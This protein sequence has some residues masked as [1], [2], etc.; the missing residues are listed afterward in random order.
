M[1]SDY[2]SFALDGLAIAGNAPRIFTRTS[3]SGLPWASVFFCSIFCCLAYLDVSSGSGKVFGWF[4]NMTSIAGLM[5]WFGINFTYWRFYQGMKTQGFD[6][7][8]LPFTSNL[9]PF[10]AWYAM[11]WILIICFVSVVDFILT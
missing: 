10:A 9:Q 6:R 4:T 5:T 8:K 3:K 7:S 2:S 11:I 1:L